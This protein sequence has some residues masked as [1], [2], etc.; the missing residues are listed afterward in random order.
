MV[1]T[2]WRTQLIWNNESNQLHQ[3]SED[4]HDLAAVHIRI[5]LAKIHARNKV[6]WERT[7]LPGVA[8]VDLKAVVEHPQR[9]VGSDEVLA[10][11]S[12][13]TLNPQAHVKSPRTQLITY[14]LRKGKMNSYAKS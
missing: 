13:I 4:D 7:E 3:S 9:I 1:Q 2:S 8:T 14:A 6:A 12:E 5:V 10:R 11:R